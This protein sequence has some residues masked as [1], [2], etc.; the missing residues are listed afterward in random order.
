MAGDG[1]RGR[2]L[3]FAL[4]LAGLASIPA[5]CGAALAAVDIIPSAFT[6]E[7]PF[8]SKEPLAF[9]A[10][11][12]VWTI[13]FLVL[14]PSNKIYVLGHELTHAIW[15]RLTG[16]KVGRMKVGEDGG[17]V[18]LSNP[19]IFTTLAPYFVPFYTVVVLLLRLVVGL[20]ADMRPYTVW[21]M[22][23]LGATYGFHVTYTVRSLAERQP[24][25]RE[26]GRVASYAIIL[27]AN[28]LVFGYGIVAI[29][30]AEPFEY[31][32]ALATRMA[33]AYRFAWDKIALLAAAARK[34]VA[35]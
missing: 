23:L 4:F 27:I 10:G 32:A 19:G 29:T 8:V 26:F 17:Y 22:A 14:P 7:F 21:W 9:L 18:M 34:A 5:I 13:L 28:L 1:K 15:G 20:F 12:T 3:R 2:L 25:I 35:R 30:G 6:A 24:D 16:S 11:Y 33:E 31:H